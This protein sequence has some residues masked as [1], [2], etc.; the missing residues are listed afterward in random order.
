MREGFGDEEREEV[1]DRYSGCH[2]ID[3]ILQKVNKY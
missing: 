3:N 1:A 2:A